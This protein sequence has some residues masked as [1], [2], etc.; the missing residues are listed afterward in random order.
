MAFRRG[1]SSSRA[2]ARAAR[3]EASS[4][5]ALARASRREASSARAR[6][7]RASASRFFLLAAPYPDHELARGL[8]ARKPVGLGVCRPAC[9]SL[10]F[11]N[12]DAL[13]GGAFRT[14]ASITP[15]CWAF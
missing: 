11:R 14:G 13:G 9:T 1:A 6:A 8:G 3:R 5:R 12:M 2:L 10:N 4:S 15:K 7:A